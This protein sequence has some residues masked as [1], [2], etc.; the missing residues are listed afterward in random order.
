MARGNNKRDSKLR[1]ATE[2][3]SYRI[4]KKAEFKSVGAMVM[5][6]VESNPETYKAVKKFLASLENYQGDSHFEKVGS[7]KARRQ[8][9]VDAFLALPPE[10]RSVMEVPKEYLSKLYRGSSHAANPGPDGT[11]NASFSSSREHA[12][13]FG[14]KGWI[15]G[16]SEHDSYGFKKYEQERKTGLYSAKDIQS[17]GGIINFSAI[18]KFCEAISDEFVARERKYNSDHGMVGDVGD[19]GFPKDKKGYNIYYEDKHPKHGALYDMA[20]EHYEATQNEF[21]VYHIKWKPGVK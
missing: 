1:V 5:D 21:L 2:E 8:A 3:G 18:N 20:K 10:I 17:V 13:E 19:W 12:F 6:A 7:H 9:I 4:P 15:G 16:R 11:V 14:P